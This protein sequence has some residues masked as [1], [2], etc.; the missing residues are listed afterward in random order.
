MVA[1]PYLLLTAF[2]YF[3]YRG[4]KK[5]QLADA[6]HDDGPPPEPQP[7]EAPGG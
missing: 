2:G 3:V 1:M 6:A 5:L 4:F 7:S